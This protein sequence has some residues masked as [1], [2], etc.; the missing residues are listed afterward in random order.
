MKT[1]FRTFEPKKQNYFFHKG[2]YYAVDKYEP[3]IYLLSKDKKQIVGE[4]RIPNKEIKEPL[5]SGD[6]I[7]T[8]TQR[9]ET[10][11]KKME[12]PIFKGVFEYHIVKEMKGDIAQTPKEEQN[13]VFEGVPKSNV[14]KGFSYN[15]W[16]QKRKNVGG[17]DHHHIVTKQKVSSHFKTSEKEYLQAREL[18][19]LQHNKVMEKCL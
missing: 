11:F 1:K 7:D 5:F 14:N 4:Y 16:N 6:M 3:K 17:N 8:H 19:R 2:K 13:K 9:V 10:I 12:N 15:H 18:S